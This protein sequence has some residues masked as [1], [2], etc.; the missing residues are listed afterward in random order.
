MARKGYLQPQSFTYFDRLGLIQDHKNIPLLYHFPRQPTN[1]K[2][3]LDLLDRETWRYS[4]ALP[5]VNHNDDSRLTKDYW[6]L[7]ED[8]R[9]IRRLKDRF[10]NTEVG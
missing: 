4:E 2:I 9:H 5:D 1:K 6:W 3:L 7:D 10:E 8:A